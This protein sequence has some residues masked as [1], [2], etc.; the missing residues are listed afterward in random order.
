MT[1]ILFLNVC[2]WKT[3]FITSTIFISILS[4]LRKK[5]V[6]GELGF[7]YT[8]LKQNNGKI[9]VFVYMTP[10]LTGQY[11]RYS[12]YRQTG[13][14]E[15][16]ASSLF[17]RAYS[18]I[19]NKDEL[20]KENAK[21]KQV[22]KENGYQESIISKIFKKITSIYSLSQ[23]QQ[24]RQATDI[25]EKEIRMSINLPYDEGT[26]EKLWRMLRFHKIKFTFYSAS[27]LHKLLCDHKDRV[28]I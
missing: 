24:Q 9:Y 8:L 21:I 20:Y 6:N 1:F 13:C 25:K 12:Y 4:L 14:K 11:L 7:L 17:N 2:I 3:F 19:P 22:L 26:S 15:S 28:A 18:I 16:V 10:T 23:L 5:K 27:T